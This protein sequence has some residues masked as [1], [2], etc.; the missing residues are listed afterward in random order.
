MQVLAHSALPTQ[1]WSI[2]LNKDEK[3]IVECKILN[4]PEGKLK[5]KNV[6]SLVNIIVNLSVRSGK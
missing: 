5:K 6:A 4:G 1:N 2:S 3:K